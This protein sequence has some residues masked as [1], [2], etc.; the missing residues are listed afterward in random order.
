MD[1][2]GANGLALP[3]QG[4][5]LRA[6]LAI[7]ALDAGRVVPTDR[8]IE[9]LWQDNPPVGVANALQ[10]LV[11]KLRKAL[12]SADL[13][14][15]RPPGYVLV[16]EPQDVDIHRFQALAAMARAAV[17][18]G[19]RDRAL[20]HLVAAETLW[21][22]PALADFTFD[23]F[24]R[25]HIGRLDELRLSMIEQ[26]VELELAMGQDTELVSELETLVAEHPVRERL[27]A[28]LMLALYRA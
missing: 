27:R 15:M 19:D 23:D 3:V 11:S 4:A 25:P 24:A 13:V 16:I 28:Q 10:R 22:G 5:K 26:R 1:V 9:D 12:G 17:A 20:E 21:S 18:T 6:V 8:L 14:V 2:E 7:L